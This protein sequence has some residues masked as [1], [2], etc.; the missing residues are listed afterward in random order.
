MESAV[1]KTA[2]TIA[3]LLLLAVVIVHP[4]TG[5]RFLLF[6]GEL[7]GLDIGL[8]TAQSP[9]QGDACCLLKALISCFNIEILSDV[10]VPGPGLRARLLSASKNQL[11]LIR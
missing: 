11:F 3:E 7:T 2:A 5:G 1:S 8:R 9:Q 4:V 10:K 6:L